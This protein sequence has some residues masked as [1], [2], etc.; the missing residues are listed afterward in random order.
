MENKSGVTNDSLVNEETGAAPETLIFEEET[1]DTPGNGEYVLQ[2]NDK[3]Y[4]V[5]RKEALTIIG[6]L[7]GQMLGREMLN[8]SD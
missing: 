5:D 4:F 6:Q 1:T 2:I 7:S 8:G 3:K